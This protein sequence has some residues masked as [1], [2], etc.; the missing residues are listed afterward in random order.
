VTVGKEFLEVTINNKTGFCIDFF[1]FLVVPPLMNILSKAN[2][3][4]WLKNNSP[5]IE[6][7]KSTGD[8]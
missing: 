6:S 1:S 2:S 8:I 7:Y 3:Y 5:Y 4:L